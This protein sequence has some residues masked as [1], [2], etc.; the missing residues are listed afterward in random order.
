MRLFLPLDLTVALYSRF[1]VIVTSEVLSM[2][3]FLVLFM[4]ALLRDKEDLVKTRITYVL[5]VL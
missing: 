1:T 4:C 2:H 3:F 5:F